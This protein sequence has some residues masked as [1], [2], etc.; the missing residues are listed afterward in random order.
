[1]FAVLQHSSTTGSQCAVRTGISGGVGI[2]TG[3]AGA[4]KREFYASNVGI[5]QDA[6]ADT[7]VEV[8]VITKASTLTGECALWVNGTKQTLDVTTFAVAAPGGVSCIST[9][10]SN[11]FF[12][13]TIWAVGVFDG[14]LLSTA[15]IQALTSDEQAQFV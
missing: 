4:S 6:L 5:G 10:G 11:A 14:E 12:K 15:N 13:G 1:V 8:R 7:S 9:L 2:T 3:T